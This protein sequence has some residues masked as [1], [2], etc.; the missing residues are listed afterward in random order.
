MDIEILN[1]ER[2]CYWCD[3][4]DIPQ[5]A[6]DE[7]IGIARTVKEQPALFEIFAS[8]HEKTALRGEWR[9]DWSP[10]PVDPEVAA[11]FGNQASMFYLLAYLAALPYVAQSYKRMGIGMDVFHDTMLDFQ[12]WMIHYKNVYGYWGF[13]QFMW[14]W[15]H[16]ACKLFRLGRLQ[17]ILGSF[18]YGVTFFR[19]KQTGE[20]LA[21]ADPALRL[22]AD[23]YAAGA[24]RR[25]LP[26][27]QPLPEPATEEGD[28]QPVFEASPEGWRGNPVSPYGFAIKRDTFLPRLEWEVALQKGDTVLDLHIPRNDPFTV[29][30]CRASLRR[31]YDFFPQKFPDRP[32][33]AAT[34]HTWFFTAQ[35][36]DLMPPESNIIRFQR[37]FYLFPYP[38]GPG[39]LWTFVFTEK[40]QD[41]ATAPR[42][43]SLRRAVLDWLGEG[44]ELFDLAGV[45]FNPPE[46]WGS[47][48]Y[49]SLWDKRVL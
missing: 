28:W 19:K 33:R 37:E 8:F 39:F 1:G 24:G 45:L 3:Q 11:T 46:A 9:Q 21:L 31:A 40:Y 18:D 15:I 30:A 5:E 12:L 38:G 29:E 6:V 17:Y 44:K 42:D 34:C 10:L 32:F 13:A 22:R 49:M 35:L 36:Q 48:V 25:P 7:L 2:L 41:P 43:T 27:N 23:G 47:Q 16:M 20:I 26:G 4:I 14:I